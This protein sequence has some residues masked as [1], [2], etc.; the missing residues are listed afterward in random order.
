MKNNKILVKILKVILI[1]VAIAIIGYIA[2]FVATYKKIKEGGS[3]NNELYSKQTY[4]AKYEHAKLEELPKEYNIEQAIKDGVVVLTNTNKIYN[5][6]KLDEFIKN[7]CKDL[8]QEKMLDSFIRVGQFTIEG[9]LILTDYKYDS[10]ENKFIIRNDSTRDKFGVEKNIT[11]KSLSGDDHYT[12][13]IENDTYYEVVIV[14]EHNPYCDCIS[15]EENNV[16]ICRYNKSVKIE[17]ANEKFYGKVIECNQN[18]MLV[19]VAEGEEERNSTDRIII[20]FEENNDMIYMTGSL[21]EIEYTGEILETYPSQIF[22]INIRL[23]QDKFELIFEQDDSSY[24]NTEQENKVAKYKV[25]SKE[26]TDKVDYDIYG[27]KGNIKIFIE[28]EVIPLRDAILRGKIE[29]EDI[30]QKLE[31]DY[32]NRVSITKG[33]YKDGGSTLYKYTNYNVLKYNKED[34]IKDLYIGN[35]EVDIDINEK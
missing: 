25:I 33:T 32:N 21:V 27:Y 34:G 13:L 24:K 12:M 20:Q 19:E 17:D 28:N 11:E 14:N 29:I 22:P 7:T 9:D 30:M 6:E 8:R 4:T 3:N 1:I 23:V 16:Y 26:E 5:K 35:L 31:K 10:N 18:N 15:I 2:F